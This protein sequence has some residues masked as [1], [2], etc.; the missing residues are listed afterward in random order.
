MRRM[1]VVVACLALALAFGAP[2]VEAASAQ[3]YSVVEGRDAQTGSPVL[4]VF[5]RSLTKVRSWSLV[6]LPEETPIGL[7]RTVRSAGV[8]V[9]AFADA[10]GPSDAGDYELSLDAGRTDPD[11]PTLRL[12]FGKAIAG[13]VDPEALSETTKSSL[14][15][16]TLGSELPSFYLDAVNLTWPLSATVPVAN[17]SAWD[18]LQAEGRVG[19]S[20]TQVAG[21]DHNHDAQYAAT[22]H[23]HDG[24]YALYGHEHDARYDLRTD[25][26]AWTRLSGVP[27]GFAD[28]VDD[29]GAYSAGTGLLLTGT[30][31]SAN[32]TT[33]A[34]DNGTATTVAR[35]N[36]VHDARYL[37]LT[38]GN[39]SGAITADGAIEATGKN[40]NWGFLV[41]HL[42]TGSASTIY[43]VAAVVSNADGIA[44]S[45][46]AAHATSASAFGVFGLLDGSG[47]AAVYGLAQNTTGGTAVLAR[48]LG[49]AGVGLS[50]T[51]SSTT[52]T[53]IGAQ[54]SAASS[55]GT[56]V[57]GLATSTT[58]TTYGVF[59]SSDSVAGLGVFG[60]ASS[61]TG[62]THGVK[63][64]VASASGFGGY[65]ENTSTSGAGLGLRATSA[66]TSG[67]ALYGD[68]TGTT[69]STFGVYGRTNSTG[70]I[71]VMGEC[72]KGGVG[73]WAQATF[74]G[75][76]LVANIQGGTGDIAVFKATTTNVARIDSSGTGYFNG[77]TQNSGADIA[78]SVV[79]SGHE[80]LGPGD[81]LVIDPA[82][83]RRF[84]R[85][86][87]AE[88][89][90]VAGV[91]ATKP[92]M[93]LRNGDVTGGIPAEEVPLA[94]VGIVPCKV[95]DEGGP[96]AIG[97]LLVTASLPGHAK[98]A[99]ANARQGTLLG[100][101]LGTLDH[102]TETVEVLLVAR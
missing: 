57:K 51:A 85:S 8:L 14:D 78:E 89:P 48:A 83:P 96:I 11:V 102:G 18:D 52:G 21:G 56:G 4:M 43:G 84:A 72:L 49:T 37:Q 16:V 59:G 63:G 9:F 23:N 90:L 33:A 93:L 40:S 35:G 31:I 67:T 2:P 62:T 70:G 88:S 42:T 5:G 26:L 66:S 77:G 53:T 19:T 15:A 54:G 17:F 101:A 50:A 3:V 45:G 69:G 68:S 95:C 41:N 47:G 86:S 27:A 74:G 76:A 64:S 94:V 71:S 22:S 39:L 81:V 34:G 100:K 30:V 24:V 58:G 99:P 98:K 29:V 13:S 36:H 1:L 87:M 38:G 60:T 7:D 92:G 25:A 44:I 20:S 79:A 65:F 32:F 91:Y 61:T 73:V 6:K 97:D 28:G 80:E 55:S 82:A 12:G 75:E 46:R 10:K